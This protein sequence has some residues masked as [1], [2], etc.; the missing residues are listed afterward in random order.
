MPIPRLPHATLPAQTNSSRAPSLCP[1]NCPVL[2]RPLPL[3]PLPPQSGFIETSELRDALRL[4]GRDASAAAVQAELALLDADGDGR[5]SFD[6]FRSAT[7]DLA[8]G[9]GRSSLLEP[10]GSNGGA[11]SAQAGA[12][13]G[14][15]QA[16]R[17]PLPGGSSAGPAEEECG[18]GSGA[19]ARPLDTEAAASGPS[20][21]R[22]RRGRRMY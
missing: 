10:G 4:A 20:R 13:R 22:R 7:W 16:G 2:T 8:G 6:E 14:R 21:E 5:I 11:G 17:G 19:E 18:E 9:D 15:R 12:E 3:L 1:Y